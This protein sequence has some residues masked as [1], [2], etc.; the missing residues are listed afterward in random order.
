MPLLYAI[1]LG[2]TGSNII[3][4]FAEKFKG[5]IEEAQSKGIKIGVKIQTIDLAREPT[6]ENALKT[7]VLAPDDVFVVPGYIVEAEKSYLPVLA[8]AKKWFPQ[9][10]KGELLYRVR[11][12][13]GVERRRPVARLLMHSPQISWNIYNVLRSDLETLLQV[14]DVIG[15]NVIYVAIVASLGGGWGSGTFIDIAAMVK[16]IIYNMAR[17]R[18]T[19]IVIGILILPYGYATL[20]PPGIKVEFEEENA[21]AAIRELYLHHLYRKLGLKYEESLGQVGSITY[22]SIDREPFDLIFVASY[23]NVPGATYVEQFEKLDSTVAD[24]LAFLSLMPSTREELEKMRDIVRGISLSENILLLFNEADRLIS[25]PKALDELENPTWAPLVASFGVSEYGI[26]LKFLSEFFSKQKQL[27]EVSTSISDLEKKLESIQQEISN[28]RAKL[29]EEERKLAG[30]VEK[31]TRHLKGEEEFVPPRAIEDLVKDE[32]NR[33]DHN[34]TEYIQRRELR[35]FIS[36][37]QTEARNNKTLF[38]LLLK[39]LEQ[40]VRQL[41]KRYRDE[42][43]NIKSELSLKEKD[44]EDNIRALREMGFL[45]KIPI[46]RAKEL[47]NIIK[48]LQYATTALRSKE[49]QIVEKIDLLRSLIDEIYS[50]ETSLSSGL[51]AEDMCVEHASLVA[52]YRKNLES[53]EFERSQLSIEHKL[54]TEE[55]RKIEVEL[56]LM[57]RAPT[58]EKLV[59]ELGDKVISVLRDLWSSNQ[60]A[61]LKMTISD[62]I[63]TARKYNLDKT[64][65]D[66]IMYRLT[67][68]L[69]PMILESPETRKCIER[70]YGTYL[71]NV[72]ERLSAGIKIL[73]A[74]PSDA[75]MIADRIGN[76]YTI[77]LSFLGSNVKLVFVRP[78]V[79]LPCTE[80]FKRLYEEY[81]SAKSSGLFSNYIHSFPIEEMMELISKSLKS[82]Q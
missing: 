55:R 75:S 44:L 15:T 24:F 27:Q 8:D 69:R 4:K 64:I 68:D 67:V 23:G 56:E 16:H 71:A 33:I 58:M 39:Y 32:I 80:E 7:G 28:T 25:L 66:N 73:L 38:Y 52:Q 62:I 21:A 20:P 9:S 6:V 42:L 22:S 26:N 59:N 77:E 50:Y 82:S 18:V 47:K 49:S 1:G 13:H 46:K 78:V 17:G 61:F 74:S 60:D 57:R 41:E 30:C 70:F 34:I 43:S 48:D 51:K 31:A 36:K 45:A 65:L 76:P 37:L 11:G 14:S 19:P 40:N 72:S 3:I 81:K 5:I 10:I 53:L 35:N 12:E 2:G 79:P 29:S 54:R 63:D